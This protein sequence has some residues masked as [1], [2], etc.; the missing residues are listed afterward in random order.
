V[1]YWSL[2]RQAQVFVGNSSSGIMETPSFALPT[3]NI[4]ERQRGRE[5]AANILDSRAQ[6]A[7]IRA[8]IAK[9]W[10]E[11]FRTSLLGMTNPYGDGHASEK[12]VEALTSSPLG[13]ELLVKRATTAVASDHSGRNP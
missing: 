10:T 6:R 8:A 5:R 11:E 1:T 4:G 12:I 7:E 2:L 13:G 9:A 3:V